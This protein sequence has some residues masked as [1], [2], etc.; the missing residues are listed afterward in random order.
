MIS[1]IGDATASMIRIPTALRTALAPKINTK[2]NS[3][4]HMG[5]YTHPSISKN[6]IAYDHTVSR[7]PPAGWI[8]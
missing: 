6:N 5:M 3:T 2:I 4:N 8:L 1:A 7:D